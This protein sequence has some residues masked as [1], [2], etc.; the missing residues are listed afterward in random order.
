MGDVIGVA[1][2]LDEG[3]LSFAKNGVWTHPFSG[4]NFGARGLFPAI[5]LKDGS[6]RINLGGGPFKFPGPDEFYEPVSSRDITSLT[7]YR[8]DPSAFHGSFKISDPL[9]HFFPTSTVG[10]SRFEGRQLWL[11]KSSKH[12]P[13]HHEWRARTIIG[14]SLH[15]WERSTRLAVA[16]I[17]RVVRAHSR[18][19]KSRRQH[20]A[21]LL[22]TWWRGPGVAAARAR[23]ASAVTMLTSRVRGFM[24]RRT[25]MEARHGLR[26]AK[27]ATT[28]AKRARGAIGRRMSVEKREAHR[29]GVATRIAKWWPWAKVRRHFRRRRVNAT[30][31]QRL[32]RG[33]LCRRASKARRVVREL[34]LTNGGTA[35]EFSSA[36]RLALDRHGSGVSIDPADTLLLAAQLRDGYRR[37]PEA[38]AVAEIAS[39][40]V[41]QGVSSPTPKLVL[42]D[43]EEQIST[44][45]K[46]VFADKYAKGV[47]ANVAAAEALAAAAP[48]Q[49]VGDGLSA[50]APLNEPANEFPSGASTLKPRE[51]KCLDQA[52]AAMIQANFADAEGHLEALGNNSGWIHHPMYLALCLISGGSFVEDGERALEMYIRNRAQAAEADGQVDTDPTVYLVLA[53]L[54]KQRRDAASHRA[55]V[56][57]FNRRVASQGQRLLTDAESRFLKPELPGSTSSSKSVVPSDPLVAR[58]AE[59]QNDPDDKVKSAS[60]DELL[61]LMGHKSIKE[62]ALQMISKKQVCL[63]SARRLLTMCTT[64]APARCLY[65]AHQACH[66]PPA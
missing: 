47:P 41:A 12:L 48:T 57:L 36:F 40:A 19:T 31:L 21:R 11:P 22:Q 23:L 5:T 53:R 45:F 27:A 16:T 35:P 34:L 32:M 33:V 42:K 7:K 2:D 43:N 6:C 55:G 65:H 64:R 62:K 58:W 9:D 51:K 60:M 24:G 15:P 26:E 13:E 37:S 50:A 61:K 52:A 44:R 59:L 14:H 17:V 3:T 63:G 39:I 20:G 10:S 8:G 49:G 1:A 46:A 56:C 29:Q 4:C 25:A 66:A 54:A 28:L 30:V 18:A 38:N